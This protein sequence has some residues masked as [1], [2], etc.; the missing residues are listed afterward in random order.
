MF[1]TKR[2]L[3]LVSLAGSGNHVNIFLSSTKLRDTERERE[4]VDDVGKLQPAKKCMACFAS[5]CCNLIEFHR[6]YMNFY[7]MKKMEFL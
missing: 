2:R 5:G 3:P 4:H 6:T 7:Q 1:V